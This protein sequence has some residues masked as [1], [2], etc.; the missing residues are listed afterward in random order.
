M[1]ENPIAEVEGYAAAAEAELK[2]FDVSNPVHSVVYALLQIAER[3]TLVVDAVEEQT[4]CSSDMLRW[5]KGGRAKTVEQMN[6]E[7]DEMFSD[8]DPV[9]A[10]FDKPVK[11]GSFI[12]LDGQGEM[13]LE[14]GPDRM[15]MGVVAEDA[16]QGEA[17]EIRRQ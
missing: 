15:F 7:L 5:V 10:A 9:L 11:K 6:Q 14:P 16:D 13:H 12:Y 17:V 4:R 2:N 1:A 8:P 3:L